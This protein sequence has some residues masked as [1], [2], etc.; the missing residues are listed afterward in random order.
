MVLM[1]ETWGMRHHSRM[2]GTVLIVLAML[3]A[4]LTAAVCHLFSIGICAPAPFC[5]LVN[6]TVMS[7]HVSDACCQP[8]THKMSRGRVQRVGSLPCT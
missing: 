2:L 5:V 3:P 4:G 7:L 1:G 6:S 8:A